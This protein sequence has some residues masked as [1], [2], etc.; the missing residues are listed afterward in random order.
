MRFLLSLDDAVPIDAGFN[1]IDCPFLEAMAANEEDFLAQLG[2]EDPYFF[3]TALCPRQQQQQQPPPAPVV[4]DRWA[5]IRGRVVNASGTYHSYS[6][7]PGVSSLPL[8][9]VLSHTNT[10]Q[11]GQHAKHPECE[12]VYE[13][14][15]DGTLRW[16]AFVQQAVRTLAGSGNRDLPRMVNDVGGS[17]DDFGS[18]EEMAAFVVRRERPL[19][20]IRH[21]DEREIFGGSFDP[22]RGPTTAGNFWGV[23]L[24]QGGSLMIAPSIQN[25]VKKH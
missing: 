24:L 14:Q 9:H 25:V 13:R 17:L 3:R 23:G 20:V 21:E 5:W 16:F 1:P 2:V 18:R 22:W 8:Q 12:R 6:R 11:G 4:G 7:H 19:R 15:A 10:S